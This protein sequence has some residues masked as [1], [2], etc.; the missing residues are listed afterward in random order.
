MR[1]TIRKS[2]IIAFAML[3][4]LAAAILILTFMRIDR[5]VIVPGAFTYRRIS[6]V[7]T[8]ESGFVSEV[9]KNE[10]SLLALNDTIL[11]LRNDDLAMEIMNSENKILIYKLGLE[12]ILQLK[13]LDVSLSS[14]DLT[15]LKEELKVKKEE[16]VYYQSVL[17]DKTDLYQKKIVSKDEY[18][19]AN[20]AL[21]QKE[22]EIKSIEIQT[23]ELNKRL[24]KLDTS[25]YLNYKLK[26]K[27]LEIEQDR[28]AYLNKRKHLLT[29]TAKMD[30][31]LVSDKTANFLNSFFPKGTNLGDIVS[32][33]EI[34]FVGYASGADIIR[35]KEGQKVF[36]N[37]D[38]FR[39]K[40]FIKG[41][42]N[43]IGLKPET[44]NGTITFPV[45]I[46]VT[47]P[48]FFDR[49]R[50]R[51]IHAGVVGEAII[52]TEED[53]PILKLLWEQVVKYADIN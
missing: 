16:A 37:V 9:K 21:K 22:L 20:I 13:E 48:D 6:P 2:I 12:E 45:E 36:F 15:K 50:K 44:M 14:Y 31:K 10:N 47:D 35:V 49:G 5:K 38:T 4:L 29:V 18:E 46:T 41:I 24:Q 34:D 40:D 30:G 23:N 42:V 43:K 17:K 11:I 26:Q 28:L 39:G 51:F 53:L 27:E 3:F 25:T 32:E 7:V 1:V 52:I 33:Q 19:A 8:E